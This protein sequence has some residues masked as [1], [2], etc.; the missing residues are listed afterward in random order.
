MRRRANRG[1]VSSQ[2]LSYAIAS[3]MVTLDYISLVNISAK[4]ALMPEFIQGDL[5]GEALSGALSGFLTDTKKRA[6]VSNALIAQTDKM[7]S[8]IHI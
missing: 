2:R 3:R 7:L 1:G 6:I 5:T 8:L 4:E